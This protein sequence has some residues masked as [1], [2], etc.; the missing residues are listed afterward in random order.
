MCAVE[1]LS[2]WWCVFI[3]SCDIYTHTHKPNVV[4][5][6]F[7]F[8]SIDRVSSMPFV[9]RSVCQ[10][11]RENEKKERKKKNWK[12]KEHSQFTITYI[13]LKCRF[14]MFSYVFILTSF[15]NHF[16]ISWIYWFVYLLH[17]GWSQKVNLYLFIFIIISSLYDE[18]QKKKTR[19]KIKQ[20]QQWNETD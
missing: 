16:L 11:C 20:K 10:I 1:P 8:L 18:T 7:P 6:L 14:S 17:D 9:F 4:S 19:T 5:L 2:F 3:F 15:S 12:F 13:V